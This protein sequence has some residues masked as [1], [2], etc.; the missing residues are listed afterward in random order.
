MSG[1]PINFQ[2]L[3][4]RDGHLFLIV[5]AD[6]T[7]PVGL[8]EYMVVTTFAVEVDSRMVLRGPVPTGETIEAEG[9]VVSSWDEPGVG[10]T[11]IVSVSPEIRRYFD[12]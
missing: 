8:H 2:N 4:R 10:T 5:D 6:L 7:E 9:R 3:K 1:G 11:S 12:V